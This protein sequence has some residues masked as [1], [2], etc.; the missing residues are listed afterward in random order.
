MNSRDI[1]VAI[2]QHVKTAIMRT[3]LSE[4]CDFEIFP[5]CMRYLAAMKVVEAGPDF[6]MLPDG[7]YRFCT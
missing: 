3:T 6:G 7:R 2:M 1:A 4:S 5:L